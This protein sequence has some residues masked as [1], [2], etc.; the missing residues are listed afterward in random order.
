MKTKH[1]RS[2]RLSGY[3]YSQNGLYFLTICTKN[4][5]CIFGEIQMEKVYLSDIG[6]IVNECWQMIPDHFP[7]IILHDYV[8]MPNHMHGIIEIRNTGDTLVGVNANGMSGTNVNAMV[9]ANVNAMVGAN[10]HSPLPS[11][12]FSKI[13]PNGTSRTVGS[14]VRGFKIGVTKRVGFSPWQRNYYERI[15]WNDMTYN[16]I[17]RYIVRNP[18]KWEHDCFYHKMRGAAI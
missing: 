1:R 8:V 6:K 18:Q 2:I 4:M 11:P 12:P 5:V 15:I 9:G 14:V 7:Q 3:D 13:R 16:N 10:N 17:V